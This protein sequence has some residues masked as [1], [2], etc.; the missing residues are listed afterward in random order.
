[1]L[2]SRFASTKKCSRA[3]FIT[4]RLK[5]NRGLPCDT[6]VRRDKS[7]SCN[8]ASN[9]SRNKPAPSKPRELKDRLNVLEGLISSLL[10]GDTVIHP[11]TLE[12]HEHEE[13]NSSAIT[14]SSSQSN[15]VAKTDTRISSPNESEGGLTTQTPRLRETGDG[16]LNYIDPSHWLSILDD[17]KEVREHLS[18]PSRTIPPKEDG[19]NV[20]RT[21]TEANLLHGSNQSMDLDEI[22]SSLPSQPI[23]DMLLSWYFDTRFMILGMVESFIM[24]SWV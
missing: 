4:F 9:A 12:G 23:C 16:Q 18:V 8:Y 1:M 5:C 6:C 11:A 21:I 22:L 2:H 20:N 3:H 15:T 13:N 19:F 7:A 24:I 17:I 10:S 14:L